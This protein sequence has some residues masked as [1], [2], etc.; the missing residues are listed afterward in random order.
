MFNE[1]RELAGTEDYELW[2]RLA[3]RYPLLSTGNVSAYMVQHKERS[4]LNFDELKLERRINLAFEYLKHDK[5]VGTYYKGKMATIGAHLDMYV[6]LHLAMKRNKSR[7]F[8]YIKSALK[9][10]AKVMFTRKMLSLIYK[11]IR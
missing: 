10:D 8:Y 6:A 2:V 4:V 1:D 3:S 9:K 5:A 7:A 11:I